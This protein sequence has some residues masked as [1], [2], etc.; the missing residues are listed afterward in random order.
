MNITHKFDA[1]AKPGIFVGYSYGQKGY[2]IYDL[3]TH[4]IYVSRDVIFHESIFPFH[5]LSSRS[6][7]NHIT[8]TPLDDDG[9]FDYPTPTSSS[10]ASSS[11]D[12]LSPPIT[13]TFLLM[14]P[15]TTIPTRPQRIRHLPSHLKDYICNH[16]SSSTNYQIAT[17]FSMSNL[18]HPH[19]AFLANIL[20]NQEP[21]SYSQAMKSVERRTAM[22][23]EI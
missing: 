3:E 19:R 23:D 1:R 14:T 20:D 16:I 17:Y 7:N 8:I 6:S 12:P 2:H 21:R 15:A 13:T 9:T 11:I 22:A 18:S 4:K 5:D 10:Q